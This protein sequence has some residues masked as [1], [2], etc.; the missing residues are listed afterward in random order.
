[1]IV[2]SPKRV[3]LV[4]SAVAIALALINVIR[5]VYQQVL[6]AELKLST[7]FIF[8]DKINVPTWYSSALMLLAALLLLTIAWSGKS[9]GNQYTLHWGLLASLLLFLSLDEV[10]S[11]HRRVYFLSQYLRVTNLQRIWVLLIIL[12]FAGSVLLY[13]K[14]FAQLPRPI[15]IQFS[16]TAILYWISFVVDKLDTRDYWN[17]YA[18]NGV[19]RTTRLWSTLDEVF[20]LIGLIVFIHALLSYMSVN[21]KEL[22]I[23]ITRDP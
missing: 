1:M 5:E 12:A 11:I 9:R 3:T 21:L 23:Y 20:E 17:Y 22:R 2:L 6:G 19:M 15:I 10:S 18:M 14:F 7:V 8:G 4:L 16:I 13:R